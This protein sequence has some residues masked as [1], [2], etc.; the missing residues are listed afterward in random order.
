GVD[1]LAVHV[2]GVGDLVAVIGD[3]GSGPGGVGD[4]VVDDGGGLAVVGV[5]A[6][7]AVDGDDGGDGLAQVLG[8]V[9]VGVVAQLH[10]VGVDADVAVAQEVVQTGGDDAA[11]HVLAAVDLSHLL[12]HIGGVAGVGDIQGAG[13][14]AGDHVGLGGLLVDEVL[15]LG[16]AQ[17]VGGVGLKDH[18]AVG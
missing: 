10:A 8:G 16:L 7:V 4:G 11:V 1:G 12:G 14:Q 15:D 3:L 5:D 2:H 6:L 13:L 17:V 9:G 18:L